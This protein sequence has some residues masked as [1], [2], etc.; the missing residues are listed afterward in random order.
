MPCGAR[1][2]LYHIEAQLY[3]MGIAHIS[4]LRQ[5]IYRKAPDE[6][7][8]GAFC[9]GCGNGKL[10]NICVEHFFT[11][12]FLRFCHITLMPELVVGVLFEMP[13]LFFETLLFLHLLDGYMALVELAVSTAIVGRTAVKGLFHGLFLLI[14]IK[15]I[16][17]LVNISLFVGLL[18]LGEGSVIF[19][20]IGDVVEFAVSL[21]S[22]F[23]VIFGVFWIS[24]FVSSFR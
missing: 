21:H 22:D 11:G 19:A 14:R 2:D 4:N 16:L 13:A 3:R 23:V 18:F 20:V 8:S 6:I 15:I 24:H 9:E 7:P 5:Q 17:F 12:F 10:C 1:R